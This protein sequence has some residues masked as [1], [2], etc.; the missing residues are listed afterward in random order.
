MQ[1]TISNRLDDRENKSLTIKGINIGL[2]ISELW[3][4]PEPDRWFR[5]KKHHKKEM[6][7]EAAKAIFASIE[8]EDI[9]IFKDAKGKPRVKLKLEEIKYKKVER[10]VA[11]NFF[12]S[13]DADGKVSWDHIIIDESLYYDDRKN[14]PDYLEN[15][16]FALENIF[17]RKLRLEAEREARIEAERKRVEEENKHQ[18]GGIDFS[19]FTPTKPQKLKEEKD[20]KPKA[21]KEE[22]STLWSILNHPV[23]HAL[24]VASIALAGG[25]LAG[26]GATMLATTSVGLSV[27]VFVLESAYKWRKHSLDDGYEAMKGMTR[28]DI[29]MLSNSSK[30]A[31]AA[32]LEANSWMGWIKSPVNTATWK[33]Y[34]AFGAGLRAAQH[35]DEDL[36]SK[37]K[38]RA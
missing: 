36:Q 20:E 10:R 4:Q 14:N 31:F 26:L 21:P 27:G 16:V 13:Q 9:K 18:D 32:G 5:K 38:P 33:Q 11:L 28:Q 34:R 37:F 35:N 30:S 22:T 6:K 12:G 2:L 15:L 29:S 19:T 24:G 25:W 1:V 7:L 17:K 3:S 23:T 8:K